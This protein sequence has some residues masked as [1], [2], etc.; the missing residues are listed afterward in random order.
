MADGFEI[1]ISP[2][3]KVVTDRLAKFT[4]KAQEAASEL[5]RKFAFRLR[6]EVRQNASRRPGPEVR[7]GRYRESIQVQEDT[8]HRLRYVT[9]WA[10]F[11][12]HPAARRLEFGFYGSDSNGRIYN[13]PPYP[14]WRPAIEKIAKEYGKEFED[15]IER[16][17]RESDG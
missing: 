13:Q 10:V 9:T 8:T 17:W 5:P 4:K 2:D 1:I 16:W 3:F 12:H 11:T 7:T 14:H 15:Q 6:D